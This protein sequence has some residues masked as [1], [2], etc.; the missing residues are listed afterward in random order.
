MRTSYVHGPLKENA[1][2][3]EPAVLGGR[4]PD[5]PDVLHLVEREGLVDVAAVEPAIND[6]HAKGEK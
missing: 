5:G 3:W 2:P 6:V 1:L 4:G